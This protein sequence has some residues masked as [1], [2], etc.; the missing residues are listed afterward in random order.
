ME[1]RFVRV[2]AQRLSPVGDHLHPIA[3]WIHAI[4]G[5]RNRAAPAHERRDLR[6]ARCE[7]SCGTLR[8]VRLRP[9]GLGKHVGNNLELERVTYTNGTIWLDKKQTCGF[10]GVPEAVWNFHIGGYQV[11]EKW[12]KDRKG[13]RLS[14]DDIAHYQKIVVALS[15]TIRLMKEIDQTIE[16]HGGWPGAF[17]TEPQKLKELQS[18]KKA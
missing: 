7:V 18:P 8:K 9:L 14:A 6:H 12:L 4:D 15:E 3:A 2:V 5:K 1:R 13:R 11:C 16:K 10:A 17:V